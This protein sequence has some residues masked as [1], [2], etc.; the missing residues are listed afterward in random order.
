M[1]GFYAHLADA[2]ALN[3]SR[4]AT[5]AQLTDGCS[6]SLSSRLIN[7]ER[8]TLPIAL[9]FDWRARKFNRAGIPIIIDDFISMEKVLPPSEAPR[10]RGQMSDASAAQLCRLLKSTRTELSAAVREAAFERAA[11]KT[12]RLLVEVE[13]LEHS[14]EALLCMTRHLIESLGF[15]ALN[16]T[17]FAQLSEGKTV[18][19]S[20]AFLAVQLFGIGASAVALDRR[21]QA[22]H[23]LG[24][25]IL[26][27][28]VPSI[29]FR[30]RWERGSISSRP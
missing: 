20:K 29:P 27:N 9:Y 21:A 17:R 3:K 1:D 26:Q 30:E 18:R 10:F 11:E 25:G 13:E 16:A 23:K 12:Y 15:G 2:I 6:K 5:Y 19:L 8:I 24:A 4:R 7:L 22:I 14:S 28:D